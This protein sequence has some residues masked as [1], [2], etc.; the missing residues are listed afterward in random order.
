VLLLNECL[1]ISLDSVRKLLDKP[2]YTYVCMYVCMYVYESRNSSVSIALGYGMDN[3]GSRVR[4]PAEAGK[5]SLH[6][7]VQ[8]ASG[9][10]P[11]SYP[12]GIG[13]FFPGSKAAGA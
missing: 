5:F 2:S 12:I 11:A 7:R 13:G 4:F 1:F 3:R 6:H 10:N 8:N 9:A